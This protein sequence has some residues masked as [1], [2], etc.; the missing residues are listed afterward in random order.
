MVARR[1]ICDDA[2]DMFEERGKIDGHCTTATKSV[3]TSDLQPLQ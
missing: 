3:F 1:T 2:L